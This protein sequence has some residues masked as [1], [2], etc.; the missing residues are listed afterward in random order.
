MPQ[1]RRPRRPAES[2][3]GG[4]PRPPCSPSQPGPAPRWLP[5]ACLGPPLV[6]PEDSCPPAPATPPPRALHP[7]HACALPSDLAPLPE[8]LPFL[9]ASP[10]C[11]RPWGPRTLAR[12]RGSQPRSGG[13][14]RAPTG[15]CSGTWLPSSSKGKGCAGKAVN[16]GDYGG[17]DQG[18]GPGRSQGGVVGRPEA[19]L[20]V[21]RSGFS[22]LWLA[23]SES[24]SLSLV[25]P[26]LPS[27]WADPR[28]F[29]TDPKLLVPRAE[30]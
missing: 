7:S 5:N 3:A 23:G 22:G 27:W 29:G 8:A 26:D 6:S 12:N 21:A 10:P 9:P 18:Q 30:G 25:G 16:P 1:P 2:P 20:P 24:E 19:G 13:A 4:F 14:G 17:S 15:S 11:R 28:P